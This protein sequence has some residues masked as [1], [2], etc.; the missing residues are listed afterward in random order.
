M[1]AVAPQLIGSIIIGLYIYCLILLS[2]SVVETN[3]PRFTKSSLSRQKRPVVLH[4]FYIR[5]PTK[6]A[7]RVSSHIRNN[8][9]Y[10]KILEFHKVVAPPPPCT[11]LTSY[12]RQHAGDTTWYK[13]TTDDVTYFTETSTYPE[14]LWTINM[15]GEKNCYLISKILVYTD[16]FR[17]AGDIVAVSQMFR[18][19]KHCRVC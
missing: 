18:L 1:M 4:S 9:S 17:Y 10:N 6:L 7:Y 8:G 3:Y 13:I 19:N 2:S 14:L 15:L 5:T 12:Y 16:T 11:K